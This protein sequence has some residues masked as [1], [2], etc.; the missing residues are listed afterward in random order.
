VSLIP[1]LIKLY[2]LFILVY[3]R[4]QIQSI[5]NGVLKLDKKLKVTILG[6]GAMGSFYGASLQ[7]VGCDVLLLDVWSE[8][9]H[10]LNATG[11]TL[12]GPDGSAECIPMCAANAADKD[13]RP[14]DLVIVFVDTNALDSVIP[15]IK[16]L[17]S[18][19]GYAL[20]LQNGVG[21]QEKLV[22]AL[23]HETVI[24]G[25]SMNSCELIGA[26]HVRHVIHGATVIG[27]I[28]G[29]E[30][31]ERVSVLCG[32][33]AR[34]DS[35]IESVANIV[36]HIWSKLVINCAINPL[37]ALTGL[38]P[39]E[40]QDS[41]YTRQLQT[42][43]VA[44]IVMLCEKMNITL[45]EADPIGDVWRKSRGGDNKPSMVQH[46]ERGRKTEIDALN[47]AVARMAADLGVAAPANATITRL[48]KGLEAGG[49]IKI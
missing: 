5:A 40:L 21:N 3:L 38:L 10:K 46:L 11:L 30:I 8:H 43:V 29:D 1:I 48:I 13:H 36:P 28:N 25:T 22:A 35:K 16:S 15:L 45:P 9:I 27:E 26:G 4:Y 44:E 42:D 23:G 33:L 39:G 41:A 32:L 37:C 31:S 20:T 49:G 2:H 47:G 34:A 12:V 17:L 19:G 14:A 18:P 24:A 6:S 7:Q